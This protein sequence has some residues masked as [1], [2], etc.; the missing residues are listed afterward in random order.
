LTKEEDFLFLS[1]QVTILDK[2]HNQSTWL[3]MHELGV[4]GYAHVSAEVKGKG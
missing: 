4:K 3:N 1:Q 2:T